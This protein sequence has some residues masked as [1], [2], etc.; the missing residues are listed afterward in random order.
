MSQLLLDRVENLISVINLNLPE[1]FLNA[2]SKTDLEH[3]YTVAYASGLRQI[4]A[5]R[6]PDA[7]KHSALCRKIDEC[8]R[9]TPDSDIRTTFGLNSAWVVQCNVTVIRFSTPPSDL[10]N[11]VACEHLTDLDLSAALGESHTA[12]LFQ[13]VG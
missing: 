4:D 10:G 11:I 9:L 1:I 12:E 8:F 3:L 2:L 7:A 6:C 5:A 13:C